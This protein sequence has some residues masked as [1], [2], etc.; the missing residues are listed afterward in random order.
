MGR[1]GP[2]VVISLVT[3]CIPEIP[4]PD[5]PDGGAP[6]AITDRDGLEST[7]TA[8]VGRR[9]SLQWRSDRSGQWDG[10]RR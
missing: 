5:E 7:P 6:V 9:V 8:G 1:G 10:R 4:V 3:G 2:L